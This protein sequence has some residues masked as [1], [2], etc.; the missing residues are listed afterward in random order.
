MGP[1]FNPESIC[2][3]ITKDTTLYFSN[4]SYF[5]SLAL[6][7]DNLSTLIMMINGL[8][9]LTDIHVIE[10]VWFPLTH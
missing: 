5:I 6:D 8:L 10:T 4:N 9:P 1:D 7:C 3:G 2:R